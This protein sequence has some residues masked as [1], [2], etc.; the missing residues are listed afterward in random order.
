M[1]RSLPLKLLTNT[2]LKRL[3]A[4]YGSVYMLGV[5]DRYFEYEKRRLVKAH[6]H[7]TGVVSQYY[8][9]ATDKWNKA[10]G[11]YDNTNRSIYGRLNMNKFEDTI[12]IMNK[13]FNARYVRYI[14]SL[15]N[16]DVH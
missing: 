9:R 7:F 1:T 16:D 4:A 5:F 2:R 15:S 10:A 14:D 8:Y 13:S 6:S 3:V 11:L 12:S